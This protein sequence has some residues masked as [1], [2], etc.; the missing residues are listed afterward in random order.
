[1]ASPIATAAIA[2]ATAVSIM[3]T[4]ASAAQIKVLTAGAFRAVVVAVVP[5]FQRTSGDTV[6][7]DN[8]TV[9][10]LMRRIAGGEA[11]DVVVASPAAIDELGRQGKVLSGS[12]TELAKVG[13]WVMVKAGAP[14]PD[15]RT[16]EAFKH[17][18]LQ[19]RSIAY[20]DPDS[21]GSSGIYV[22]KLLTR[23]GI[24][25]QVKNKTKLKKGGHVSDLVVSGEAELGIHQ[26]S[27]ILPS[28]DV[29]LVGP[30]PAE[31]QNYTTYAAA[32]SPTSLNSQGAEALIRALAAP[33][34]TEILAARGMQR[35]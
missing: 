1:M 2:A 27:E 24:A 5:E 34:A 12:K 18:V 31:I 20:I 13:V 30:L 26:I 21:G 9:G 3:A 6:K 8:D 32:I 16:V 23:L 33:A 25:D 29:S 35:P 22:A 15:V 28:R 10:A 4:D 7:V 17:A 14:R 19:A 11:F